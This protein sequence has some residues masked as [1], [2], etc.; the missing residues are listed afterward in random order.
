MLYVSIW[1]TSVWDCLN[2]LRHSISADKLPWITL[3]KLNN[4]KR[5]YIHIP[6]NLNACIH[7]LT[8]RD[9]ACATTMWFFNLKKARSFK[10]QN[11]SENYLVCIS[12]F[13]DL[14]RYKVSFIFLHFYCIY[15]FL[16]QK[17][18]IFLISIFYSLGLKH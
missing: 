16:L 10:W 3:F 6:L 4:K 17:L 7:L 8:Y 15:V 1:N 11:K 14:T 12:E 13:T 9:D 18:G 2:F 5:K